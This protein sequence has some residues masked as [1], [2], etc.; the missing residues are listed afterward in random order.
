MLF[1]VVEILHLYYSN[2]TL[3][4]KA[5]NVVSNLLHNHD[6]D[7]RYT[8]LEMKARL[9]SLYLPIVGIVIKGE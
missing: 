9:A 4:H 7:V 1:F 5:I 3:H 6:V 8:D 2:G